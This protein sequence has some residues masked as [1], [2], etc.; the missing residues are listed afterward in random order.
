MVT[1]TKTRRYCHYL[2]ECRAINT[3]Y[4]HTATISTPIQRSSPDAVPQSNV[5]VE[6]DKEEFHNACVLPVASRV[7]HA[8]AA[9]ST[10][11]SRLL[12]EQ[13]GEID[14]APAMQDIVTFSSY[15]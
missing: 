5:L 11:E 10:T 7:V 6:Y 1:D 14:V 2:R 12:I 3:F 8:I 9:S 15:S 4:S 13:K